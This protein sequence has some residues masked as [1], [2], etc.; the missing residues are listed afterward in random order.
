MAFVMAKDM[1]ISITMIPGD[2]FRQA[3]DTRHEE[4]PF[5]EAP[6]IVP[7]NM[8]KYFA[9]QLRAIQ[10]AQTAQ[11]PQ[12]LLWIVARDMPFLGSIKALKGVELA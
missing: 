10:F 8:P 9:Q 2:S 7:Y 4:P 6:Y 1:A 12:Q 11:P 3:D 5:S